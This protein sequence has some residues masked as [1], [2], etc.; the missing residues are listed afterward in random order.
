MIPQ[1][2]I[3]DVAPKNKAYQE[4]KHE[5]QGEPTRLQ[6][7]TCQRCRFDTAEKSLDDKIKGMTGTET[8]KAKNP[9]GTTATYTF[10]KLMVVRGRLDDCVGWTLTWS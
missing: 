5:H 9:S 2:K 10:K 8:T 7:R 3:E 6:L 1:S 4:V